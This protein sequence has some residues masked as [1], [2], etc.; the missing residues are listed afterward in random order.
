MCRNVAHLPRDARRCS[1]QLNPCRASSSLSSAENLLLSWCS[2]SVTKSSLR[3]A[4]DGKRRIRAR[5][6]P[7]PRTAKSIGQWSFRSKS[8]HSVSKRITLL[9]N[10]DRGACIPMKIASAERS[11]LRAPSEGLGAYGIIVTTLSTTPRKIRRQCG[12][13][14]FER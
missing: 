14:R 2:R 13:Q 6:A 7:H 1:A 8:N 12:A 10:S 11:A 9:P 3:L 4:R 5:Q